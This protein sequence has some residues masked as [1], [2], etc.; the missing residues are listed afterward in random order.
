MSVGEVFVAVTSAQQAT[1]LR[2]NWWEAHQTLGR[3][4]LHLGEVRL[5]S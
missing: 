3:A 4:H 1:F 5:V 2:P